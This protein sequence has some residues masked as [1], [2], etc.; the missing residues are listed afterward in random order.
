MGDVLLFLLLELMPLGTP[1]RSRCRLNEKMTVTPGHIWFEGYAQ[2]SPPCSF[3]V[4]SIAW[5]AVVQKE[6]ARG[7]VIELQTSL[8][9]AVLPWEKKKKKDGIDICVGN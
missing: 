3:L 2:G 6:K 4:V 8:I 7:S 1:F 5:W 9:F